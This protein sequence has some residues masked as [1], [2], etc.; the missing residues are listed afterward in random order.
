MWNAKNGEEFRQPLLGHRDILWRV[1]VSD[2]VDKIVSGSVDRTVRMWNAKTGESLG[3]P[4]VGHMG[5]VWCV[6]MSE[7]GNKIVSGS[8][9]QTMRVWDVRRQILVA[10]VCTTV[11][12]F[13]LA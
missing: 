4:L 3:Q 8:V 6:A 1:V 13:S 11:R 2:S 5:T 9:D 12:F 7:N 10:P